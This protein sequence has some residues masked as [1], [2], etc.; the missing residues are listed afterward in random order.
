MCTTH[1]MLSSYKYTDAMVTSK[2]CAREKIIRSFHFFG[3][4]NTKEHY[5][6]YHEKCFELEVNLLQQC[7]F[8]L[9]FEDVYY[10]IANKLMKI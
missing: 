6:F 3:K 5:M 8:I 4:H 7:K 10:N 9:D 1:D 2:A